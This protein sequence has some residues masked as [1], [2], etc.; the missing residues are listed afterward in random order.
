MALVPEGSG[1]RQWV[2]AF[3]Q[4]PGALVAVIVE[5]AVMQ[6]AQ[7]NRKLITDLAAKRMGLSKGQMMRMARL[8]AADHAGL[9]GHKLQMG[10]IAQAF[11]FRALQLALVDR[12]TNGSWICR[13]GK[14]PSRPISAVKAASRIPRLERRLDAAAIE[15]KTK[16]IAKG[17]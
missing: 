14:R 3:V 4:P 7:R 6:I 9:G 10:V 2:E 1:S 8:T 12:G 11:R 15:G 13:K 17:R 16:G 5:L